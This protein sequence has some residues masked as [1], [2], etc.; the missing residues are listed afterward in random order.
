MQR[1][2]E[3]FRKEHAELVAH[4]SD[5]FGALKDLGAIPPHEQEERM[6]KLV[7]FLRDHL[8]PHAQWEERVL[9]PLVE[10]YAG[11]GFT[12][13]MK[14]EHRIIERWMDDLGDDA[15]SVLPD[16]HPFVRRADKLLGLL[17]AHFEVEEEVLL[18]IL[19]RALTPEDF[20]RRMEAHHA[21]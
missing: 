5:L 20:A 18:P 9:Y 16:A 11:D 6:A 2:T 1:A 12:Q 21:H 17:L 19:D 4:L 10:S 7:L 15:S 3:S 8:R 14:H 13:S